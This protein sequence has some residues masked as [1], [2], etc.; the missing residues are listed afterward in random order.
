MMLGL[1]ASLR[2]MA[3]QKK[4]KSDGLARSLDTRDFK[5]ETR[6][7]QTRWWPGSIPVQR[8]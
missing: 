6:P 5:V 1:L 3:G 2:A 7:G 4:K 8:E